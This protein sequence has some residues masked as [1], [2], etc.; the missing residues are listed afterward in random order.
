MLSFRAFMILFAFTISSIF[1]VSCQ[2][3]VSVEQ[4]AVDYFCSDILGKDIFEELDLEDDESEV[5]IPPMDLPEA[6]YTNGFLTDITIFSSLYVDSPSRPPYSLS[7]L[8][9]SKDSFDSAN[10]V[11]LKQLA[12]D[13]ISKTEIKKS[14]LSSSCASIFSSENI[15]NVFRNSNSNDR[16]LLTIHSYLTTDKIKFVELSFLTLEEDE[17][18]IYFEFD[19][20]DNLLDWYL[21]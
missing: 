20:N 21:N 2:G 7:L 17:F 13:Y 8:R 16:V 9:E 12:E 15:E 19:H 14:Q 6:M 4:K 3:Y 18:K 10:Y 11:K 5:R 1:W